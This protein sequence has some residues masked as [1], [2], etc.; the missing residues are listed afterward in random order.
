MPITLKIFHFRPSFSHRRRRASVIPIPPPPPCRRLPTAISAAPEIWRNKDVDV[1]VDIQ[2]EV[3]K[4]S[5]KT[6]TLRNTVAI[7]MRVS[8]MWKE[9][10]IG[11]NRAGETVYP[12]KDA[13][14]QSNQLLAGCNE[15]GQESCE[16]I[17]TLVRI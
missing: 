7:L 11:K 9:Y 1:L 4:I 8:P 2:L 12:E 15:I 14:L 10:I 17:L 6:T 13:D 3:L 5:L 16:S